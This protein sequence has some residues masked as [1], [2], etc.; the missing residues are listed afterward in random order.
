MMMPGPWRM[1]LWWECFSNYWPLCDIF[2]NQVTSIKMA[3][4]IFHSTLGQCFSP[5]VQTRS[6]WL[7]CSLAYPLLFKKYVLSFFPMP[8]LTAFIYIHEFKWSGPSH[9]WNTAI[10]KVTFKI[11]SQ[12]YGWGQ[13]SRSCS[14]SKIS[15]IYIPL[16]VWQSDHPFP[17]CSLFKIWPWKSKIKVM[18][19]VNIQSR[20][21]DPTSCQFISLS[22]HVNQTIHSWGM[23]WHPAEATI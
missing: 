14:E 2:A 9:S 17:K 1:T 16:I 6:G 5:V 8:L 13:M 11:Y 3:H 10:S 15:S 23:A 7:Q 21:V 4:K 22:F 18:I 19:G 20:I 12:S